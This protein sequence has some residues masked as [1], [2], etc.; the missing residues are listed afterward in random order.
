[1][2][3]PRETMKKREKEMK[4]REKREKKRQRRLAKKALVQEDAGDQI[5]DDLP[6]EPEEQA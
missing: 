3:K 1:M 2:G 6:G 4:R 5:P